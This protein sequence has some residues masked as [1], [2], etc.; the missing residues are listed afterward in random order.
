LSKKGKAEYSMQKML[1]PNSWSRIRFASEKPDIVFNNLLCHFKKDNFLEAF[2][3][4]NGKKAIGIDGISKKTY[5]LNLEANLDDLI[6]RIH[7]GS[8]RPQNKR[9]VEIPKAPGKMRP[10]AISCFEDKLVEWVIG[11][12]LEN[13]YEPV[14]I[15]NSFGFRPNK[16]ADGAIKAVYYSLKSNNRPHVVEIDFASFF[17][18]IPYDKLM[19]CLGKRISDNRFKGLIGR[20]LKVGILEQSGELKLPEIG[21]PQ[22]S[23][24][25][26]LLANIYLHYVLDSWFL[27]NYSSYNNIIVR[28]ADDAVFFFKKK[29]DAD[30]FVKDLFDR[31]GLYGLSLNMDKT[32]I[33]DFDKRKHNSFNFLGFTF[34]W[35]KKSSDKRYVLKLKTR[36]ET[37][38]RKIKDFTQWI[39]E[40]RNRY[41]TKELFKKT[42]AKLMGH[43]Q[44][45]GYWMN[46][47]KLN[48]YYQEVIKNLFKWLNRRSQKQSFT[49]EKFVRKLA[50]NDLPKPPEP[51]KLKNL[52]W[53]PYLC[54]N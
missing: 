22:G 34:Y 4:L 50:F 27:E 29:T 25:S 33:I 30:S 13:V 3:A 15:R 38:H 46:T 1:F 8:Y 14:F 11:K 19:K 45:Y 39:K 32:K 52:G 40:N 44:Y 54:Q 24:M 17:N 51:L 53:R 35:A 28:Y 26:P 48:H 10:I 42:R 36:K 20:F 47:G 7:K 9:G 12:I 43:Y 23:V 49:W 21:T 16:S 5:G 31:V 18:T 41:R 6:T 2:D 37:L